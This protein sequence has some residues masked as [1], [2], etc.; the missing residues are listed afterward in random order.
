MLIVIFLAGIVSSANAIKGEQVWSV[1]G[2]PASLNCSADAATCFFVGPAYQLFNRVANFSGAELEDG[3]CSLRIASVEN[4][5]VG[6]W[7]CFDNDGVK[8]VVE[9]TLASRCHH[10]PFYSS[11]LPS[12]Q[13]P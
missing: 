5:D 9:L 4:A 1:A 10:I 11:S 13:R 12:P 7:V 6:K 3:G 8:N 2:R